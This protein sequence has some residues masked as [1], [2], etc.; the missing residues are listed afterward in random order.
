MCI[1]ESFSIGILMTLLVFSLVSLTTFAQEEPLAEQAASETGGVIIEGAKAIWE[2]ETVMPEEL[3]SATDKVLPRL[4]I[5]QAAIL[6]GADL[7]ASQELVT[8][9]AK[10]NDRL[11]IEQA[12]ITA[13][14]E[15]NGSDALIEAATKTTPRILTKQQPRRHRES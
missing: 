10:V 15:L 5:E 6:W 11:L 13:I 2:A 14:L 1:K 7:E 8:T 4:L 3:Q 9:A 12:A